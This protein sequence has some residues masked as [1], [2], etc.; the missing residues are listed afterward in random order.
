VIDN[1]G[2]AGTIIGTNEAAKAAPD[3]YTLLLILD[4]LPDEHR[5][6][7]LPEAA[8]KGVGWGPAKVPRSR[9]K[10][11]VGGDNTSNRI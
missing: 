6:Q 7:R 9:A 3:G 5:V 4:G 11:A 1:R 10:A 2:G 8:E